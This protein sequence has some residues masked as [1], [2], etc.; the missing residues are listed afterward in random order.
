[1]RAQS[2]K[3]IPRSLRKALGNGGR[4]LDEHSRERMHAI[5]KER[6]LLAT[7]CE[8]RARLAG[9]LER[10]NSGAEAMMASLQEWCHEAE[11]TGIRTLQDFAARLRGY[12]LAPVRA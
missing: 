1:M 3:S 12:S 6:P 10:G 9:V 5:V 8:F 7:V 2:I 11:A 4:W